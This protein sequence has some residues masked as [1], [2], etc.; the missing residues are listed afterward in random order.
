MILQAMCCRHK[1]TSVK[2]K[3]VVGD[4]RL[5][6]IVFAHVEIS[7]IYRHADDTECWS[8]FI[9]ECA[10]VYH[11]YLSGG[12][13]SLPHPP[14]MQSP[15]LL[16]GVHMTLQLQV[17]A[18]E[19]GSRMEDSYDCALPEPSSSCQNSG[20]SPSTIHFVIP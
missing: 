10:H 6:G 1:D 8:G 3:E 15:V 7:K 18:C 9:F 19:S 4:D 11:R 13:P 14:N 20:R 12:P 5:N 17:E 16:L 2:I